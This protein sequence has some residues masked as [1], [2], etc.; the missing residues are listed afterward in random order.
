[1]ADRY[2]SLKQG[3]VGAWIP[4]ISGSGLLLPDLSGRGN[5]GTLTNMDASDWVSSE[6]G[7]A[8]DFDG[9]NDY[10]SIPD[11]NQLDVTGPVS[12]AIWVR[13]T[14]TANKVL[15]E[16]G[17]NK[18]L[19]LQPNGAN[20]FYYL[21][22]FAGPAIVP[23][24]NTL[25][26]NG[27]WH[28]I[29]AT[30]NGATRSLYVDGALRHTSAMSTP[31]ANADEFVIGARSGSSVAWQGQVDDVRVYNRALS[32]SEIRLLA[33]K[34]GIGLEPRKSKLLFHQFPSGAKRRLLLTGQT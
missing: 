17:N 11:S 7:R 25:I 31:S 26:F 27:S 19:V 15:T 10:V 14:S 8:L 4:S 3:L 33:S 21:D 16:K 18:T 34:R 32:E 5:H 24:L 2:A 28:N 9:S 29:T 13:G 22:G 12:L 30:F 6:Y 23:G 1:M 20:D